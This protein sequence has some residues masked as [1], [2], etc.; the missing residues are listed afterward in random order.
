MR[1]LLF[2][3]FVYLVIAQ[4]NCNRPPR[5]VGSPFA[6]NVPAD[7]PCISYVGRTAVSSGVVSFDWSGVEFSLEFEGTSI[8]LI[9]SGGNQNEY[10]ITIDGKALP[11]LTITSG[12]LTPYPIAFGLT[13]TTHTLTVAK[14]TEAFFGVQA[15]HTI[16]LD[17]GKWLQ[18]STPLPTRKLEFIGD[19]ITCG[20]GDEGTF[21]CSFSAQTENNL[22]GYSGLVGD[23]FKAQ[24][25]VECWSGKGLVRN[26]GDKNITS[27]D[28]LP[29]YYNKT[30][31]SIDNSPEWEFKWIPN[32]VVI[33]LGTNDYSTQPFPPQTVFIPAYLDFIKYIRMHYGQDVQ[34]FLVCGPMTG[35]PC[36]DYVQQV[37]TQAQPNVHYVNLQGILTQ[38]DLGCD[39]HPNVS[40]HSKMANITIPIIGTALNWQ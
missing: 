1:S 28:P 34:L 13:D 24:I 14:R 30:L 39:Y 27:P 26:Y 17:T 15:L 5:G 19:S 35:S 29:S 11:T 38:S 40:G 9:F 3:I 31:A 22:K 33:N 32:G 37:V 16:V 2:L 23:H 25:S 7:N 21:P 18:P 4:N 10:D 8:S 20:Y 12:N 6:A 36:C